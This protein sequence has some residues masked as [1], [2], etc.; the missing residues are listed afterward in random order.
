MSKP[1][2]LVAFYSDPNYR[3]SDLFEPT[4]SRARTFQSC[5]LPG[6]TLPLG[7]FRLKRQHVT[8]HLTFLC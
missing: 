4:W 5:S 1:L 3:I 8:K 2:N 7:V 6:W